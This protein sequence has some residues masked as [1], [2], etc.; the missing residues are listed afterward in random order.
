MKIIIDSKL[1]KLQETQL[2]R[3]KQLFIKESF[4][5]HPEDA[6]RFE[7]EDIDKRCL[8]YPKGEFTIRGIFN[9]RHKN[10][11]ISATYWGD[12]GPL[13]QVVH[14]SNVYAFSSMAN[15][16]AFCKHFSMADSYHIEPFI[17][18]VE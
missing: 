6:L 14:Y 10:F 18:F 2:E 11:R 7:F 4:A 17:E 8:V 1:Q 16:I 3:V 5:G 13:V 15:A 9:F 12:A